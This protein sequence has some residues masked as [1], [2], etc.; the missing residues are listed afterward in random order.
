MLTLE[1]YLSV[2]NAEDITENLK[3]EFLSLLKNIFED[4]L[5]GK[6]L[7]NRS[8]YHTNIDTHCLAGWL[9][10]ETMKI[11]G[12]KN[13]YQYEKDEYGCEILENLECINNLYDSYFYLNPS[14]IFSKNVFGFMVKKFAF[15]NIETDDNTEKGYFDW[16]YSDVPNIFS[17][18]APIGYWA[19]SFCGCY[20]EKHYHL[21][22]SYTPFKERINIF[23]DLVWDYGFNDLTL[24]T[25]DLNDLIF[26][27]IVGEEVF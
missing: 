4:I 7:Y 9:E 27:E 3:Y 17:E 2:K 26:E 23:N 1:K 22:D 6:K 8:S 18:S 13:N 16:W 24:D 19:Y 10:I 12:F 5:A 11:L 21:F 25:S 15:D 14:K 20:N